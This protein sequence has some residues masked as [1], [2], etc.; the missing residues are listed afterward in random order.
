MNEFPSNARP[1]HVVAVTLS[2]RNPPI[3]KSECVHCY[4]GIS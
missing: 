1:E 2:V 4:Y 3:K